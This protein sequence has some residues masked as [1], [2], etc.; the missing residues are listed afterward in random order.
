MIIDGASSWWPCGL[1]PSRSLP[2]T[3]DGNSPS[4]CE[5]V[6]STGTSPFVPK[7]TALFSSKGF[8]QAGGVEGGH[9][10]CD[11]VPGLLVV[12]KLLVAVG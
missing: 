1:F 10:P 4:A 3:E 6:D 12:V 11:P 8:P 2:K 9:C 7:G 5:E